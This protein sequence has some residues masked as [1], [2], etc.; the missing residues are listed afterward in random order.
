M[1]AKHGLMIAREPIV[2]VFL[3][4]LIYFFITYVQLE[5]SK[6]LVISLLFYRTLTS[7]GQ[8]QAEYL[9]ITISQNYFWSIFDTIKE[10]HKSKEKSSNKKIFKKFNTLQLKNI[11]FS[12]GKRV[13]FK[14]ANLNIKKNNLILF[15]GKSGI[16]K[17]T[18]LDIIVGFYQPNEGN[19][20]LNKVDLGNYDIKTFR[21]KIGF[22]S[23]DQFIYNNSILKNI[24][25]D[26]KIS[27]K[28][29]E[30]ALNDS[31]CQ[32]FI[33]KLPKEI[34]TIIGE[35][36]VSL[37]SGQKQRLSIARAL[38]QNPDLLIL[39]EPTVGLDNKNKEIILKKVKKLSRNMTVII[40]SH[41][42][43]VF[44]YAD[45]IYKI[46]SQKLIKS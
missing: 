11:T 39:D 21:N 23:Q 8:I 42:N 17:T 45:F 38:L 10:S 25:L 7:L 1:L 19:V 3:T 9:G 30:K 22:V 18:L 16:G 29:L 12:F 44:K 24:S 31:A 6:V 14:K 15:H 27:K 43:Y 37:S 20:L 36:G 41:D 13:I 40:V 5:F 34:N 26:K 46:N 2:V 32:D 4:L 28:D 35:R 33:K